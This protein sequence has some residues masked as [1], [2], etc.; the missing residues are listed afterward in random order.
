MTLSVC[1]IVKNEQDVIGRCLNC[2]A[3]FA[4]EIIVVDTGSTDETVAEAKK[5][6]DKLYFFKWCDDFSAAR[7]Y[8]FEQAKSDLIMWLDADDVITDDNCGKIINL[9]QNFADYDMAFLLYAAAFDGDK[10]AFVYNRE[11]IFRRS[12][13][14]RFS[15]AVHEAVMPSGRIFYSDAAIYHKKVKENEPMRNLRILQKQIAKGIKFDGRQ[16]FYYGRELL[17]NKMYREAIAVLEDFLS[18]DGWF[19]NK[20][21][22]CLNLYYAYCEI[23]D[24][25]RAVRAL[26]QSFIY[27]PP[28]SQ[29][30]CIL[31]D[32]FISKDNTEAAIYWYETALSVQ[33][34]VKSGGFINMDFCGFIPNM[35]L[36]V[37]YDKLGEYEKADAYNEAAGKF[38]PQNENYLSNKKYF[39]EKL[40]IMR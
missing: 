13:N 11:R 2:A 29:A 7:N 33:N 12:R 24:K 39:E 30:C 15:G 3:K 19:V 32:Y 4:D 23:G 14:Y 18:G 20:T 6:T 1:L 36:C 25:E 17:F 35:Q 22:A 34:D 28:Q 37:L 31:G 26:L 10:P 9:K 5:F 8:A 38:K 27:A 21:E 16:K 40:G